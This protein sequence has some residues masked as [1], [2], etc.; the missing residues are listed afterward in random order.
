MEMGQTLKAS[1]WIHSQRTSIGL[2]LMERENAR[3]RVNRLR[4][5]CSCLGEGSATPI[6]RTSEASSCA[7]NSSDSP[8]SHSEDPRALTLSIVVWVSCRARTP[9]P[10]P[11]PHSIVQLQLQ[12]CLHR[13]NTQMLRRRLNSS[14]SQ[15]RQTLLRRQ[16]ATPNPISEET[17]TFAKNILWLLFSQCNKSPPPPDYCCHPNT[18]DPIR[19]R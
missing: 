4:Q 13:L 9:S 6:L 15:G 8:T 5:W 11:P 3:G 14:T 16:N 18:A 17:A 1:S 12:S 2:D 10:H 19:Q 7:F